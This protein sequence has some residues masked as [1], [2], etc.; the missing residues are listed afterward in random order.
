MS[1]HRAR[2]S[3]WGRLSPGQHNA[4]QRLAAR[5][6]GII[7]PANLVSLVGAL[8]VVYGLWAV[9]HGSLLLGIVTIGLGR[10]ADVLDGI[11]A[12]YT[13]TKSALGEAV[14]ATVDKI[15]LALTLVTVLALQLLPFAVGIAMA[16]HGLYNIGLYVTAHYRKVRLHP[17]LIGKLATSFEWLS[18][19]LY[20]I[21]NLLKGNG[22][23]YTQIVLIGASVMFGLF[24][25]TAIRS[26]Y[27]YTQRLYYKKVAQL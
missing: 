6:H 5:T 25:A 20:L 22:S 10:G 13:K 8:L 3:D 1:L 18:V 9:V 19:A 27:G 14:D 7:T 24:V 17:S 12:D 11:V 2:G 26:S 15:L 16:L 23:S 4:W 21:A